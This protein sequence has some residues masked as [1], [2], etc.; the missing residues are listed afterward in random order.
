MTTPIVK[1]EVMKI[2]LC[3]INE[4]VI[5]KPN[6]AAK[7]AVAFQNC[8]CVISI[9]IVV[10]TP[11]SQLIC[12][13]NVTAQPDGRD[14]P[15]NQI[16]VAFQNGY[17]AMVKMIVVIVV[18]SCQK[19]VPNVTPIPIS[20]VATTVVYQN[21]GRVISRTIAATEVMKTKGF[22][23]EN[24]GNVQNRSS[25]VVTVNV[26]RID[27]VVIMKMIVAIIRMNSTVRDTPA[28]MVHSNV[29]RVTVLH[30]TSGV[31]ETATVVTCLMKLDV[32]L[33]FQVVDSVPIP[34][35]NVTT[36]YV[37]QLVICVM[38]LMIAVII[39]MRMRRFALTSIA[40]RYGGSNVP[41]TVV[42]HAIKFVMASITA[43]TVLTKTT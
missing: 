14:V 1:M 39:R 5:R 20:S 8:G 28:K 37:Y 38:V 22:A 27:G 25:T 13:A 17:S 36:I 30:R 41:I 24:I 2:R 12:V 9:T 33:A 18:T 10:M 26:F 15:A 42:W 11:M 23:K 4:P 3:V 40:I 6:S 35:S 7:M 43:V 29:H 34:N 19:I 31:M 32:Q 21:N 16:I